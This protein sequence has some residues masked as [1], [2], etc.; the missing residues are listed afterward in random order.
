MG[1]NIHVGK[2]D[3]SL[4]SVAMTKNMYKIYCEPPFS[5]KNHTKSHKELDFGIFMEIGTF[6]QQQFALWLRV[7]VRLRYIVNLPFVA[8]IIQ[9]H[10]EKDFGIFMEI[11]TFLQQ[12]FVVWLRVPVRFFFITS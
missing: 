2:F 12:Q 1:N 9:N 3:W 7:P 10:K 4:R 5:C 6:L 8:K 11:W